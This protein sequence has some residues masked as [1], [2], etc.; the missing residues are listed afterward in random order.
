[1]ID[2]GYLAGFILIHILLSILFRNADQLILPVVMLLTGLSFI[3]LLSLQDP[4]RDWFLA[5]STLYYFVAG[6]AGIIL[7]LLFDLRRFTSD[8]SLYR[9]FIFKRVK[10]AANGWPWA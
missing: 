7:L 6:I 2:A 10:R 3:T 5:K 1:M 4:L 8:S 9:L